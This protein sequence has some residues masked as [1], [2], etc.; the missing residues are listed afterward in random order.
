MAQLGYKI[1]LPP[2]L[3]LDE[4]VLMRLFDFHEPPKMDKVQF[5]SHARQLS[6][7]DLQ[8]LVEPWLESL[9]SGNSRASPLIKAHCIF[10][11]QTD[12]EDLWE[13]IGGNDKLECDDF[14]A[15]IERLPRKEFHAL[16]TAVARS[17]N[18]KHLRRK[19]KL[20]S[21]SRCRKELDAKQVIDR[22]ADLS[23][24]VYYLGELATPNLSHIP[25]SAPKPSDNV[26]GIGQMDASRHLSSS[27]LLEPRS[28]DDQRALPTPVASISP[29]LL[30]GSAQAV[31]LIP[32]QTT[33]TSGDL[34][35]TLQ[36][37]ANVCD[38][39]GTAQANARLRNS[40]QMKEN[41]LRRSD[42][43]VVTLSKVQK[44]K[45]RKKKAR[46][47]RRA[48]KKMNQLVQADVIAQTKKL[49][50]TDEK[51]HLD[52]PSNGNG[53]EN[54]GAH[55]KYSHRPS[56]L[57]GLIDIYDIQQSPDTENRH[58]IIDT[59]GQDK[60]KQEKLSKRKRVPSQNNKQCSF[61][62]IELSDKHRA[63]EESSTNPIRPSRCISPELGDVSLIS[64][65]IVAAAQL[66]R[67]HSLEVPESVYG[68][69][70]WV[71]QTW[72]N[73]PPS[74]PSDLDVLME[75]GSDQNKDC[76][77][78]EGGPSEQ[79]MQF[80]VDT[81]ILLDMEGN[82]E[83][84]LT[85]ARASGEPDDCDIAIDTIKQNHSPAA[86]EGVAKTID[87]KPKDPDCGQYH[88]PAA[89]QVPSD[90]HPVVNVSSLRKRRLSPTIMATISPKRKK[91][92]ETEQRDDEEMHEDIPANEGTQKP[93]TSSYTVLT[94]NQGSPQILSNEEGT[95]DSHRHDSQ[96]SAQNANPTPV[97]G[98]F[99]RPMICQIL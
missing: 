79:D 47:K 89:T 51:K 35:Q 98:D 2:G 58:N 30:A 41:S 86:S 6:Y 87:N 7:D 13:T 71:D 39:V 31:H 91:F 78:L 73:L 21:S 93:S 18:S 38:G 40:K 72:Q 80:A 50:N 52:E 60:P 22:N 66:R 90:R 32:K 84:E 56:Q 53:Y 92:E 62:G 16:I 57:Y 69:D 81:Q 15:F 65:A 85:G 11:K 20:L 12:I 37:K 61:G 26:F 5:C 3:V 55:A 74:F 82:H 68:G 45:Q 29:P 42:E 88:T 1:W 9:P 70:D 97:R 25:S 67:L 10:L 14:Q 75:A 63:I 36:R 17:G 19:A 59:V 96:S 4:D 48:E 43:S 28:R 95:V 46:A 77:D 24:A 33:P 8:E 99:Y 76:D 54:G 23:L 49:P 34:G 64:P 44:R 27:D 83:D 94:N